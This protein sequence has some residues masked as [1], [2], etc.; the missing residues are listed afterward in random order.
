MKKTR[1]RGLVRTFEMLKKNKKSLSTIVEMLSP[2]AVDSI[3]ECIYNLVFNNKFRA[4]IIKYKEYT[5]L[6][7]RMS[8]NKRIWIELLTK[9]HNTAKKKRFMVSQKG[10]GFGGVLQTILSLIPTLL[11][12]VI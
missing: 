6:R 7:R 3:L 8:A 9:Q 11:S 4:K 10:G 12:V 2:Q 5:Q 1:I